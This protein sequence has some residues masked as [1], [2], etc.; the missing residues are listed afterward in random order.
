MKLVD[1]RSDKWTYRPIDREATKSWQVAKPIWQ[2]RAL[3]PILKRSRI[4]GFVSRLGSG[5][6]PRLCTAQQMPATYFTLVN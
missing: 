3:Y 4:Q 6:I 5:G 2:R 1:E